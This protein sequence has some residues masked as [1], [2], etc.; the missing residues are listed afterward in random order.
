MAKKHIA[1]IRGINVGRAKRVAMGDLRAL[2]EGLGYR[3][4]HTLLNSGNVV[5][6][7]PSSV[8]GAPGPRI[9]Q[10]MAAKLG[11]TARVTVI[12]SAEL[13]TAI[14]DN[15]LSKIASDPARLLVAVLAKA[16]DRTRIEPL[17][18]KNWSPDAIA[19]GKR[20]A[21]VWCAKS[22]LDSPVFEALARELGDGV[23]TRNW[24]TMMKLKALC[25][26]A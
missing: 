25:E 9:E 15:P 12:T 19:I 20:V 22:Q 17:A 1:L 13:A 16:A 18:R 21:Y 2:I 3:D 14:D 8:R 7:A 24:A 4:V 26:D 10:A 23:T 6:S 5:F 11:I